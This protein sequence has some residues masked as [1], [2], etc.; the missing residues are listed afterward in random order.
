[1]ICMLFPEIIRA[2]VGVGHSVFGTVCLLALAL[3]I[4]QHQFLITPFYG[5]PRLLLGLLLLL[6]LLR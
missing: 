5:T 1:M 4:H 6:L 3:E 2:C